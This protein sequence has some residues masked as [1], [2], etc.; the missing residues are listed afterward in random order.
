MDVR[1]PVAGA[2]TEQLAEIDAVVEAPLPRANSRVSLLS[3]IWHK[4]VSGESRDASCP[5]NSRL[6]M[7][8][9]FS[10]TRGRFQ[11]YLDLDSFETTRALRGS[12]GHSH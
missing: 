6:L 10:G 11:F 1:S 12:S 7:C 3:R 5:S 4:E 8:V 9:S 2:L